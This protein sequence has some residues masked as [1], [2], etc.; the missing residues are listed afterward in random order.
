MNDSNN[1]KRLQSVLCILKK[2]L[3]RYN[4]KRNGILG[5][6]ESFAFAPGFTLLVLHRIAAWLYTR[7]TSTRFL[8]LLIWRYNLHSSGCHIS[9]RSSLGSGLFLPHPT[10][11][12]V[13]DGVVIGDGATLYQSVTL[14]VGKDGGYPSLMSNVTVHPGAIVVG[15][16]IIGEKATIG[17]NTFISRNIAPGEV[18]SGTKPT[19]THSTEK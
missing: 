14:G 19:R 7:G 1:G 11:I 12:V 16:T 8:G 9:L 18:I 13:G 10:A 17:A 3:C 2:D 15:S 5:G 6:I 4:Y